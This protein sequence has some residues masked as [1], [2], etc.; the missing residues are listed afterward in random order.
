MFQN[1][2]DQ[3][4]WFHLY[5]VQKVFP[6]MFVLFAC[7][8]AEVE[9]AASKVL[10]LRIFSTDHSMMG[11]SWW[12]KNEDKNG[13]FATRSDFTKFLDLR[14]KFIIANATK[15][16][17]DEIE[18][19]DSSHEELALAVSL[20]ENLR[21]NMEAIAPTLFPKLARNLI[22]QL[23]VNQSGHDFMELSDW[24]TRNED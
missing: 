20:D 9:G 12:V 19:V 14:A 6:I 4:Q 18:I 13:K 7:G 21:N 22:R 23:H 2:P 17:I 3:T 15:R 10:D 11:G 5:R 16:G 1:S 24:S 8:D